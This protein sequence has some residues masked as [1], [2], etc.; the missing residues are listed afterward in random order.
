M[1]SGKVY[2]WVLGTH[3]VWLFVA[4]ISLLQKVASSVQVNV[5][6]AAC[7]Y[8]VAWLANISGIVISSLEIE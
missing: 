5:K 1:T 3:Y 4:G 7:L 2:S 6:F 8:I